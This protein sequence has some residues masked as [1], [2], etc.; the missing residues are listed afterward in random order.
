MKVFG[1]NKEE[2]LAAILKV[3][4]IERLRKHLGGKL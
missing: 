2:W 3:V 4:P 1:V